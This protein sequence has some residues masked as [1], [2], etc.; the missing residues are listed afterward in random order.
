MLVKGCV[1][2]QLARLLYRRESG[3]TGRPDASRPIHRL[4]WMWSSAHRPCIPHRS[5]QKPLR[6]YD[7]PG[8]LTG[9]THSEWHRQSSD[10]LQDRCE[11][12]SRHG[13]LRQLERHVLRVSSHLRTDLYQ[14]LPKRR[15]RPMANAPGQ[16]HL[17]PTVSAGRRACPSQPCFPDSTPPRGKAASCEAAYPLRAA[18]TQE[19]RKGHYPPS[20]SRIHALTLSGGFGEVFCRKPYDAHLAEN[21]PKYGT[22]SDGRQDGARNSSAGNSS[23]APFFERFSRR[24]VFCSTSRCATEALVNPL[25]NREAY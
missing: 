23:D 17:P 9:S 15:Q 10:P 4:V 24:S 7:Q 6:T 11:Q 19:Y 25:A 8:F 13:D 16:R 1:E 12:L 21:R 14:L 22:T 20:Y 5:R 2:F 18:M 3:F